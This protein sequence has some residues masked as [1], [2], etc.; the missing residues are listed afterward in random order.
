MNV[1]IN[2]HASKERSIATALHKIAGFLITVLSRISDPSNL[3]ICRSS[4]LVRFGFLSYLNK[5][6]SSINS[7]LL[8]QEQNLR[9]FH[10]HVNTN[11]KLTHPI[12]RIIPA[13]KQKITAKRIKNSENQRKITFIKRNTY[14]NDYTMKKYMV[15][16]C[17]GFITREL[18]HESVSRVILKYA[19]KP[20]KEQCS[21]VTRSLFVLNGFGIR[22]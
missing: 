8:L 16:I 5:R 18:I 1:L 20:A 12:L 6:L 13:F 21:R 14:N 19:R 17:V 9:I 2:M 4:V 7:L 15:N 22:S 11:Y 10:T 3:S